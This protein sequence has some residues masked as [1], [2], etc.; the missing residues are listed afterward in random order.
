MLL[1]H[2]RV[3]LDGNVFE[4]SLE[5][6]LISVSNMASEIGNKVGL[7]YFMKLAGFLHDAGKSD[8][9][10]Q[11]YL[12]KEVKRQVNH[13]SAGALFIND[14]IQKSS[15]LNDIYKTKGIFV[16]F[17]DILSYIILAHHGLF[18]IITFGTTENRI[19]LR[20]NYNNEDE[21]YYKE[22]V[23]PF[24]QNIIKNSLVFVNTSFD[25][26]IMEAYSE[27]KLIYIKLSNLSKN[28]RNL[29]NSKEEREY[30]ISCFVRLCLSI[31]KEADVYDSA[32]A[33]YDKKQKLWSKTEKKEIWDFAYQNIEN[34]YNN[35][36][37]VENITSLNRVRTKLADSASVSAHEYNNGIYKLE[38]P[39]GAGKTK[40]GLRYAITNAKHFSRDRVFYITAYLS[41]LE[42][43]AKEI[44]SILLMDDEILEHHSNFIDDSENYLE[45]EDD[46]NEY[47]NSSYLKESWESPIILTTMVQFLNTLFKEKSSNIRRFC[48]LINSVI[49]ID[50]V[51]SLPIKVL[52]NF[53]LMMNFMKT[54]MS[55]NIVHCTATQP[56]LDSIAMNYQIYYGDENCQKQN[57]ALIE[58]KDCFNRVDFYNL[59]G[60]DAQRKLSND[61]LNYYIE[62]ELLVFD[63]CLIVLN[64]KKAVSELF[65]HLKHAFSDVEMIYLTTNLC[66]AHRLNVISRIK[67]KL[68]MNR[69]S[70]FKKKMICV[71]T[72]LIE[73]GVDLDFDIVFR[74]MAGIDSIIQC[75]GRCN[76]EGKLVINGKSYR[77]KLFIF[78]YIGES[79]LNLPDIKSSVDATEYA[80][81]KIKEHHDDCKI[82]IE[83]LQNPYFNKYYLS[84]KK[85]MDYFDNRRDCTLVEELGVNSLDRQSYLLSKNKKRNHMLFQAFKSAAESFHLIDDKT[86]SVIVPY[87]NEQLLNDLDLKIKEKD[88][89]GVKRILKELQRYCVNIY[90]TSKVE[91]Y[92]YKNDEFDIY[93]LLKDYYK[94]DKGVC[95][96]GLV[97]YIL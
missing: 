55:C 68:I 11:S 16:Y 82:S 44:K 38:L 89:R 64:T 83:K 39:T 14:Y 65:E 67:E 26:L 22:D 80:L 49:L 1:A 8:R 19:D 27:F 78:K 36:K 45:H 30:Y 75:A 31:L 3:D 20:L 92:I 72:Q 46:Y 76:R 7:K 81:R 21:Y 60:N 29:E 18:D 84:N 15:L 4:Q 91:P 73:A 34:I 37:K 88:Y 13:S 48:K 74:S 90:M 69:T 25:D 61:D 77:G 56:V 63:S 58:D 71:S 12:I 86:T 32:N 95:M 10:F 51:Q 85:K 66:A 62:K 2:R 96:D 70:K 47:L 97:D 40:L 79:L 28:N 57:I 93:F 5:E 43:N 23:F 94:E 35:Y 33:F 9:I 53:N 17:I 54:I 59:T 41:V 42:Q 87:M 6:H 50:E 24:I 52:S